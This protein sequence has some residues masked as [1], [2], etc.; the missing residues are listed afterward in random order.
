MLICEIMAR[1]ERCQIRTS[2]RGL[3]IQLRDEGNVHDV[4]FRDIDFVSRYYSDPWWGR[5]EAISFT[6]IPR[7]PQTVLGT[8][9][10]VRVENVRGRAENSA[11]VFS[12]APGH[13][14]D[15][16]F[17]KVDLTLGRS[18]SYQGG[19]YDNRPTKAMADIVPHGTAGFCLQTAGNVTLKKCRVSWAGTAPD[20]FTHALEAEDVTGL[21]LTAFQGEAAHPRRDEAIWVH[22]CEPR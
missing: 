16:I 21:K 19:L 10:H 7:T 8:I 17:E 14:R 2:S 22:G 4:L 11:R 1:F 13:I 15:I 5:G 3:T 12:A 20:Y 18:T 9:H 6:A